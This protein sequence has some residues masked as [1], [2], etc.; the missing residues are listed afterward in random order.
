MCSRQRGKRD[1]SPDT[2]TRGR[3]RRPNA[4]AGGHDRARGRFEG[5][6]PDSWE[7]RPSHIE[8]QG[9][10]LQLAPSTGARRGTRC[11]LVDV[12]GADLDLQPDN[13]GR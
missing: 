12:S 7:S 8:H 2:S 9:D 5:L 13:H 11:Q 3:P 10:G 4:P 1:V 6:E